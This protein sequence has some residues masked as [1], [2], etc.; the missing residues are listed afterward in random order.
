MCKV[1]LILRL[2]LVGV[3]V[4]IWDRSRAGE[5]DKGAREGGR[6]GGR[7]DVFVV[8]VVVV[9]VFGEMTA[10]GSVRVSAAVGAGCF[11]FEHSYSGAG[12]ESS[13]E[14]VGAASRVIV[15]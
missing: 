10:L 2:G 4:G 5:G 9:V 12:C 13:A 1:K 8:V 7:V 3:G 6:E 11:Q 14:C 15:L